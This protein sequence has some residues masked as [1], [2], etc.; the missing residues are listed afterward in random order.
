MDSQTLGGLVVREFLTLALLFKVWQSGQKYRLNL[1]SPL[2]AGSSE[3]LGKTTLIP[4]LVTIKEG[5]RNRFQ[6]YKA[7]NACIWAKFY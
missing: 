2:R 4:K 6:P 7:I 1:D 5:S 3:E